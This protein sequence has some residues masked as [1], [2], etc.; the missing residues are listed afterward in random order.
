[1]LMLARLDLR[2]P[3]R[4]SAQTAVAVDYLTP[5][6]QPR[7]TSLSLRNR[8]R[9]LAGWLIDFAAVPFLA[10]ETPETGPEVTCPSW[11]MRWH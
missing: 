10:T 3:S 6:F 5:A 8:S 9:R 11:L 7:S 4:P 1:M 2:N